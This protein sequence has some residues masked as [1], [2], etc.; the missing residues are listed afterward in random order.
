MVVCGAVKGALIVYEFRTTAAAAAWRKRGGLMFG[1]TRI[2][3][4]VAV[5][6]AVAIVT[7]GAGATSTSTLTPTAVSHAAT[8]GKVST[9]ASRRSTLL[10]TASLSTWAGAARYLRAI[11]VDPRGLV[12]QRGAR[13]YAGP[14]CPGAGWACTSTA[15]PVVQIA[16]AGGK[17]TFFCTSGQCAVV[18]LTARGVAR[19]GRSLTA[20]APTKPSIAACVKNGSGSNTGL[21]QSCSISQSSA[22]ND[23]VAAV[24]ENVGKTSGPTQTASF[25][26]S[27]TQQATGTSNSNTAC[28]YQAITMDGSTNAGGKK[29]TGANVALEAHQSVK[30]NQDTRGSGTNNADQSATSSGTCNPVDTTGLTQ[31]QTLTSTASA[32]GPIVQNENAANSGPNVLLDIEQNRGI[33]LNVATGP[34]NV[35]FT[36]TNSLTAIAGTTSG[37]TSQTQSSQAGSN[38]AGGILATVNQYSTGVLTA[39]ANQT[40]TQCEDA[41]NTAVPSGFTCDNAPSTDVPPS[42]VTQT[43][44][45]PIGTAGPGPKG[46]RRLEKTGK[47]ASSQT[48][49]NS[50]DTFTIVQHSTQQNDTPGTTQPNITEGDCTTS[51]NCTVNQTVTDGNTTTQNTKAGPTVNTTVNCAS[52]CSTTTTNGTTP[53]TPGDV[54]VSVG[55]GLVKEFTPTGTPVQTLDTG[56]NSSETTGLAF[57]GAGNLYVTTFGAQNVYKFNHNG[58]LVGPFGSG[59]NLDPESI[60]FDSS[61][62]A[63]VGQAD[64]SRNVLEFSSLGSLV[65]SFAPDPEGRG[66]DWIDLAGCTLYYTSEGVLV[67][68]FDVCAN[69]QLPD[70]ASGLPGADAYA[71][72][73]LPG[74][75]ALVADTASIVRLDNTGAVAQQYGTGGTLWFSLALDPSGAAFWASDYATGTVKEF[76]LSDGQQLAAF[77]TGTSRA[78]GLAIAP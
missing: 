49:G 72:K 9:A 66:T 44:Y 27:I 33:G 12:I 47:D 17:N 54:L 14:N 4:L 31:S 30:I 77:T 65:A 58:A 41:V 42:L 21:G 60:V 25:T 22:T 13:N 57:D 48:G 34:G 56:Q 16:R 53:I 64:G 46:Q 2:F 55:N 11:G 37:S 32:S 3:T 43:Q 62:N 74:G 35:T 5:A 15:H 18:Q 63:F 78:S 50:A 1:W 67:K 61:G 36:Q 38:P 75:G 76:R 71:V 52:G 70:F 45:G 19:S 24:Y 10:K 26:A 6:A 59:Y 69:A 7:G 39:N 73:L 8:A 40:E 20:S 23:N 68:R 28:V 51:G 29:G